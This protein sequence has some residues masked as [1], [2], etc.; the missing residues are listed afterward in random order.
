MP[1]SNYGFD[2]LNLGKEPDSLKR[3]QE[4]ELIHCRWAM[5]GTAGALAVELFGF[6]DWVDAQKWAL[7]GGKASWFGVENPL[8]LNTIIGIVSFAGTR[9]RA[10][11]RRRC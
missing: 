1:C 8:D 6:G 11:D 4:A 2:P 7:S 10:A 3:F 9:D 5:L